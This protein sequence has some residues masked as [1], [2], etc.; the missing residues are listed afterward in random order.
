LAAD[1]DQATLPNDGYESGV[2]DWFGRFAG[3]THERSLL[4][5]H[6]F[7]VGDT[8]VF[9]PGALYPSGMSQGRYKVVRLLP[10]DQMSQNQYRILSLSDEHERVVREDEIG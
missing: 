3:S 5:N 7:N 4:M 1:A 10:A 9:T 8:V 6:V 2:A